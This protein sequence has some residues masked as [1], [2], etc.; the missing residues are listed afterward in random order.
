MTWDRAA[1]EAGNWPRLNIEGYAQIN[2]ESLRV[3]DI[4]GNFEFN[5]PDALKVQAHLRIEEVDANTPSGCRSAAGST[6]A[7]VTVNARAEWDW[8]SAAGTIVE[9]GTQFSLINGSLMGLDGYFAFSGD[10]SVGPVFGAGVPPCGWIWHGWSG[11]ESE[12]VGLSGR[13][14]IGLYGGY[15]AAAGI[16]FGKDLRCGCVEHDRSQRGP[17]FD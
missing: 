11:G 15:E 17:R 10:V 16:F 4:N 13:Q 5:V 14:G 6:V 7:V 9:V 2:D 12:G 3:L 8:I 1:A